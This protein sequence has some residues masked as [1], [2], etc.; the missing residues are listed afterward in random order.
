M[1][2]P[3]AYI[4]FNRPD[5]TERTFA[6]LRNQ[7]P[8]QLFI[9]ADGPRSGNL[10]DQ[11]RCAAVRAIV[12]QVDWTCE[13][14]RNYSDFNLGLKRRVST[15][16]DWVFN[17]VDRAIIL[18]DDCLAHPDFF[19]FTNQ[20]LNYYENDERIS[21]ITGQ[22]LQ[23][24]R[25]I[26]NQSYYFSIY[27]HCWGWATWRRSWK[28][29]RGDILFWSVWSKSSDW[30]RK[31][32]D[33]VERSHWG[34]VF[35][36]VYTDSIDSWAYPWTASLWRYGGLTVT[37]NVNLVSNI[38]FGEDATHTKVVNS[39]LAEIPALP[40]GELFHPINVER[41]IEADR[42]VFDNV[43]GGIRYRFPKSLLMYLRTVLHALKK[44]IYYFFNK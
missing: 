37:P 18:E 24:G 27:P 20:L 5:L 8:T 4:V 26:G 1:S 33:H 43:Y 40:L 31:I 6:I 21:V 7:K 13:V 28:F 36:D 42:W 2:A 9:I 23:Y 30:R 12:E 17:Q 34:R 19:N 44:F 14:Y 38:G 3:I 32:P 10:T 39:P 35:N 25:L 29:Y 41:N 22:N 11:E 15:G 16:L